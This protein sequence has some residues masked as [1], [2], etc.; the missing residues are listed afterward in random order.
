M[1]T[2]LL[3]FPPA[4]PDGDPP[5]VQWVLLDSHNVPL[6]ET[7]AGALAEAAALAAQRRVVALAP[8]EQVTLFE[9][10]LKARSRQQLLRAVPYALEDELAED[11][12]DLHFALGPNLGEDRYPVAVVSKAHMAY[13]IDALHEAGL[14]LRLLIPET[15]A[16][17]YHDGEWTLL[18]EPGR[19]VV[20]TGPWAGFFADPAL[21][22]TLLDL[23]WDREQT[24]PELLRCHCC[25]E[26]PPPRPP[27]DARLE[28]GEQCPMALFAGGLDLARPLDLLQGEFRPKAGTTKW[29]R[30]WLAAGVLLALWIGLELLVAWNDVRSYRNQVGALRS[31]IEA[32][33]RQAFPGARRVV[34]ARVQMEQKLKELRRAAGG[35]DEGGLLPLLAAGAEAVSRE[36]SIR[37]DTVSYR[38]GQVE[39]RLEGKELQA[40]ERIKQYVEQKGLDAE[41]QSA[42]TSGQQISA[43]IVIRAKQRT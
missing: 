43:R 14:R 33:Y 34:N 11:V 12:E 22:G 19:C 10:Q 29:V 21:L 2:L 39:L 31:Q 40:L 5:V 16:L 8:A 25:S 28:R 4:P 9:V 17:P 3:R 32:V 30:P 7:Q 24:H 36:R 26:D 13:W 35:R 27:G 23:A 38:Q 41:I 6:G 37:V 20:R 1:E 15:L 42:D 18:Q